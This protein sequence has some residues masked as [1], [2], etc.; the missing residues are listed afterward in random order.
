MPI[1]NEYSF[2]TARPEEREQIVKI[3]ETIL[4]EY[5]YAPDYETSESDIVDLEKTY[6][7]SNGTFEVV[8]DP[9]GFVCGTA[10]VQP[11]SDDTC[12][13]RK[14]YLTPQIRGRGLGRKLLAHVVDRARQL[15]FAKMT[16][17]TTSRMKE[18]LILYDRFGF[19]R[20][21]NQ[22]CSPRCDQV[23]EIDL[24]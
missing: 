4:A 7:D 1:S 2:R 11:I 14:M 21:E 5:G 8:V 6:L 18:A 9:E 22:A 3:V 17:E 10:A 16:L 20:V 15:G 24:N 13:L 23:F 12:K 19:K